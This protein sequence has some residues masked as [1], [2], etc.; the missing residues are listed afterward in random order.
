MKVAVCT[1][2][3]ND[4][5]YRIVKYGVESLKLYC[6]KHG[7]D[8]YA[9]NEVYDKERSCAWYKIKAIELVLNKGYDYVLWIDADGHI[10]KPNLDITYFI[11]LS[12]GKD[13]MCGKDWNNP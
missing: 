6:K 8:F 5:Y 9:P 11:K 3:L 12:Q 4:W 2:Y 13:L 1:L 10:L 7:Y